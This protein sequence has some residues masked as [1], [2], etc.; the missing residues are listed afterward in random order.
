MSAGET[1]VGERERERERE[2][3]IDTQTGVEREIWW[4]REKDRNTDRI[5]EREKNS[6][7]DRSEGIKRKR[8]G[9]IKKKIETQT[10]V[11]EREKERHGG[12]EKD[13][14]T[15]RRG[16]RDMVVLSFSLPPYLPLSPT[17]VC[18]SIFLSLFNY[19]SI[20][21]NYLIS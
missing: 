2:R 20:L 4:E 11:G 18:V 19:V 21:N 7:T 10:G 17:P 6:S 12:R 1:E 8:Y 16:E 15:D 13:R 14:R 9:G 5:W 3:Q